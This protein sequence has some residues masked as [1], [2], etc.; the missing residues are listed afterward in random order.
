MHLDLDQPAALAV[1]AAAAFDVETEPAGIVA[2]HP[3]RGKLTEQLADRRERAGVGDWIRARRASD[4]ALVDHD[5]FIELIE[6]AQSLV[7]SRFVFRVVEMAKERA[8]QN[9]VHQ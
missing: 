6:P 1:L 7:N 5:R 8:A 4:R 9:V 3:R 2:A